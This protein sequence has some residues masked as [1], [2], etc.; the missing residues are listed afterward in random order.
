MANKIKITLLAIIINFSVFAEEINIDSLKQHL[1]PHFSGQVYIKK[2]G[3]TTCNY[4]QGFIERI[5]GTPINDSTIFNLGE[6]SHSFVYYF[7]K[8]LVTLNQIKISDPVQKYIQSFPYSNITVNHLLNHKSGLPG[9]YVR[10]YHK[11]RFQNVDV[12]M[13]SKSVRFD[14]EDIIELLSKAKPSLEFQP[15]DSTSYS[16]LNYLLLASVI[17]KT[18]FTPFKD[19]SD[20]LFKYQNFVFS[21]VVSAN[22]DTINRRAYGYRYFDDNSYKLFENLNSVGFPFSDGTNGNQHIYLSAKHLALWGQFLFKDMDSD[23]M[24]SYPNKSFFGGFKYDTEL[25]AIVNKGAFGGSYHHLIY[26]P[27]RK[28]NI[29]ITSNV[30]KDKDDFKELLQWLIVN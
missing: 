18:T 19:F 3:V 11:K 12:K 13:S 21:P 4:Y 6:I 30:F 17:E 24:R 29:V 1:P 22:S 7:V 16:G 2:D 26:D 27:E 9:S 15:G 23:V 14:N 8:H 20:R 28:L 25:K 5:Y 10:F